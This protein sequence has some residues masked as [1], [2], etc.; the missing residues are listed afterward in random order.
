MMDGSLHYQRLLYTGVI[1]SDNSRDQNMKNV[2]AAG[3][4]LISS[5]GLTACN[6]NTD[7]PPPSTYEKVSAA[8]TTCSTNYKTVEAQ[9]RES[10][11]FIAELP[12][13]KCY[14]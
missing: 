1:E 5:F 9:V 12:E 4:I 6:D 13:V 3:F 10:G 2:L 7:T 14:S 8:S 11:I